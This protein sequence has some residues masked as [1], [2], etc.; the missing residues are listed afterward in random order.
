MTSWASRGW[1]PQPQEPKHPKH[2]KILLLTNLLGDGSVRP[3]ADNRIN[4][5]KSDV[6]AL[7]S[8]GSNGGGGGGVN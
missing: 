4:P 8:C 5:I 3:I 1:T 7:V 6:P 2:G